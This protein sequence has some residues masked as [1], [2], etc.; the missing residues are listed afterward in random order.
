MTERRLVTNEVH[1]FGTVDGLH[2]WMCFITSQH[3]FI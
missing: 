3:R 1:V 2:S